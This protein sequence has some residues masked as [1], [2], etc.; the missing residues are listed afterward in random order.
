MECYANLSSLLLGRA[1]GVVLPGDEKKAKEIQSLVGK[2]ERECIES[3]QER[4]YKEPPASKNS[5]S[6]YIP[7]HFTHLIDTL[8]PTF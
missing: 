4:Y 8:Q 5:F 7:Q 1:R 3:L 6:Y 2:L